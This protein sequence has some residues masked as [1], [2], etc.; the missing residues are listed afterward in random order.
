MQEHTQIEKV[1]LPF[2][3]SPPFSS[4]LSLS[5]RSLMFELQTNQN[6]TFPALTVNDLHV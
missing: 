1:L 4:F 5:Y 6:K 3:S 2:S